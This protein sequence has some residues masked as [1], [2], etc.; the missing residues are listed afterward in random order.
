MKKPIRGAEFLVR[1]VT[2]EEVFITEEFTEEQ[3]MM[4]EA[5]IEFID[6]EVWPIKERLEEKD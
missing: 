6:R 5:M 1:D 3:N 2:T 4:K